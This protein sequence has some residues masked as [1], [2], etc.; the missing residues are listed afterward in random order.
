MN[1]HLYVYRKGL[2]L[3]YAERTILIKHVKPLIPEKHRHSQ[4]DL[5]YFFDNIEWTCTA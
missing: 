5:K 4:K 1:N 2:N 3:N